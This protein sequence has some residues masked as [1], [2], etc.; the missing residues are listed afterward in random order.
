[1]KN[2][3]SPAIGAFTE[4]RVASAAAAGP[5]AMPK[6]SGIGPEERETPGRSSDLMLVAEARFEMSVPLPRW[7]PAGACAPGAVLLVLGCPRKMRA[8]ARCQVREQRR[9]ATRLCAGLSRATRSFPRR[10]SCARSEIPPRVV[11]RVGNLPGMTGGKPALA[12][13]VNSL[14]SSAPSGKRGFAKYRIRTPS[15]RA[16][17]PTNRNATFSTASSELRPS[18]D[19]ILTS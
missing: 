14:R 16:S 4:F 19:A 1:M 8:P 13:R 12:A 17:R 11:R 18:A 15:L 9:R 3:P 7:F 6:S 10:A 2:L 5:R